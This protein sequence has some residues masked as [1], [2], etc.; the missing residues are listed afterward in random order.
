M[1]GMEG[2]RKGKIGWEK[3]MNGGEGKAMTEVKSNLVLLAGFFPSFPPQVQLRQNQQPSI[4]VNS[5]GR[6]SLVGKR[7]LLW[8]YLRPGTRTGKAPRDSIINSQQES[9]LLHQKKT[10][11]QRS[12]VGE[13]IKD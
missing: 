8:C 4:K 11:Q 9:L 7:L 6:C 5:P 12:A 1:G 3:V 10:A 13:M 2:V